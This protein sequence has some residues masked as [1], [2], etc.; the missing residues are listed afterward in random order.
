MPLLTPQPSLALDT[1]QTAHST[2]PDTLAAIGACTACAAKLP[3]GPRPVVHAFPQA[4]LL[5]AGQAPGRRV[6]ETGISFNDASG[7]RLRGWLGMDHA[8]FYDS[9][10]V[11]LVPMA[12]CY[13]GV[14]PKGGDR[15]PPPLCARLWR[16]TLLAHMPDI[17]LTLLVGSY[18]QNHVL[19]KGSVFERTLHFQ[20]FLPQGYFPLPHPSW[21]TGQWERH[22]PEFGQTV[23]PALRQAVATALGRP[24]TPQAMAHTL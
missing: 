5:I 21:R 1:A 12:F 19:G 6:H 8:T 22:T 14:L 23:L 20:D 16:R 24:I 18:S 15:P 2:L 9:G 3:L 13:P 10:L 11:A 4:R 7:E 17:R